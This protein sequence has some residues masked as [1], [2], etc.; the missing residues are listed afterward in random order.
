MLIEPATLAD[1]RRVAEVHVQA[2]QA[3]Y[4]GIVPDAYLASLSVDKR[5]TMWREA[6]EKQVPELLVARVDGE[7]AGWVAFDGSRDAG[8][9]TGTG[10]IWALYVDPAHWSSGMGRAL[11][12]R[13]RARLLERGVDSITLWVLA[14]NARAINFYEAAGFALEPGSA[15]GFELGGRQVQELRYQ[16]TAPAPRPSA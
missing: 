6:I 2:W 16:W 14:A 10:E 8:A 1:A 7:V 12:R 9:A 15:K 4:V 13:A 5:E 3:A 11:W